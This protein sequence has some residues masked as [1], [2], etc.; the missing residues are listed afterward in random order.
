MVESIYFLNPAWCGAHFAGL[1]PELSARYESHRLE[2]VV[3]HS[4]EKEPLPTGQQIG[5]N[6][7]SRN[8]GELPFTDILLGNN[9]FPTELN[10]ARYALLMRSSEERGVYERHQYTAS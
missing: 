7:H 2:A 4:L 5:P 3:C 9:T 6:H 1:W 8:K 10:D